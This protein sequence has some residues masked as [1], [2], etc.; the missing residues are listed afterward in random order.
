MIFQ[1]VTEREVMEDVGQTKDVWHEL[2]MFYS[3]F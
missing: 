1:Q 2:E 3:I